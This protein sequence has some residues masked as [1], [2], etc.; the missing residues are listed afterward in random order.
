[1]ALYD[2]F[3]CCKS[4]KKERKLVE[5]NRAF[6]CPERFFLFRQEVDEHKERRQLINF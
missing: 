3:L 5:Y 1:M 6:L 4:L 2:F